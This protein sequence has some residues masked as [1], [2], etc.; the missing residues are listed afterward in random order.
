M[1]QQIK[2]FLK[3]VAG[4]NLLKVIAYL[5]E[6]VSVRNVSAIVLGVTVAL[7]A[8]NLWNGP[9]RPILR[10]AT[11]VFVSDKLAGGDIPFTTC[12]TNDSVCLGSEDILYAKSAP[13]EGG[14]YL[15]WGLETN[16]P[17]FTRFATNTIAFFDYENI[18]NDP[19]APGQI[20][21]IPLFTDSSFHLGGRTDCDKSIIVNERYL[22]W[23]GW[24]DMRDLYVTTTHE[25]IHNQRGNF[26][27]YPKPE[28]GTPGGVIWSDW[29]NKRSQWVETH[30]SAA[31]TEV[32]AAMCRYGDKVACRAFWNDI[33]ASARG[34][35]YTRLKQNHLGFLFD[36]FMNLF[37][38]THDEALRAEKA[39]RFWR[40]GGGDGV[41]EK[42]AIVQKYQQFPWEEYILPGVLYGIPLD[43]GNLDRIIIGNG[44][45]VTTVLGM[46]FDDS[47]AMFGPVLRTILWLGS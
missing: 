36:P 19:R 34:S 14:P 8:R 31:T 21:F 18:T 7:G 42:D 1:G 39:D 6:L 20:I 38:R 32:L 41:Q 2:T 23:E 27:N 44:H 37:V 30:T 3:A 24:N 46:P 26:C 45:I 40:M 11:I 12:N 47:A 35:L 33:N 15:Q 43:T 22:T 25:L 10:D 17:W 28:P 29:V 4:L 16:S 9:I 5:L 13:T